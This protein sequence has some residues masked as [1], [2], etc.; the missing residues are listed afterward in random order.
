[1]K[2]DIRFEKGPIVTSIDTD[3]QADA[4]ALVGRMASSGFRAGLDADTTAVPGSLVYLLLDEVPAATLVGGYSVMH[5]VHR[6]DLQPVDTGRRRAPGPA[7]QVADLCA[8]WQT[9]G[10]IMTELDNGNSVPQVTGPVAPDIDDPDDPRAWHQ[11][12]PLAANGVRRRR[13]IDVVAAPSGIVEIDAFFRDSHMTPAG[14]ETILHEYT[15]H[16]V[17][18]TVR[19]RIIRCSATPRVLPWRECPQAAASATRLA[20]LP[21]AGL[22]QHVRAQFTGPP[23]CT[24]LN[25]ALRGLE[26]TPHLTR[27]R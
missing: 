16:A 4:A 14:Q 8:G 27:L 23:T 7:L 3:P 10:V 19:D 22:R 25:D 11:I 1:M 17:A 12:G 2:V 18:D 21:F 9:G 5:A 6:G 26:D 24:H 13:R 20:Q 15:I